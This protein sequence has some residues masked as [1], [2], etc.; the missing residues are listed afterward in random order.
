MKTI[1]L[2]KIIYKDNQ[3]IALKFDYDEDLIEIVKSIKGKKSDKTNN[4]WY[5]PDTKENLSK[6][7]ELFKNKALLDLSWN[8]KRQKAITSKESQVNNNNE[9]KSNIKEKD[10]KKID[11]NI[12][13]T[14]YSEFKVTKRK[15]PKEYLK[16]LETKRCTKN[17]IK[18]YKSMFLSFIN[19]FHY[20][21]IDKITEE[22]IKDFQEYL[23]RDKKVSN[24]YQN[25]SINAIKFYYEH[26]SKKSK[27]TLNFERPK[28]EITLPTI[29]TKKEIMEIFKKVSNI[30]H[31][32]ILNLIYSAGLRISEVANLKIEDID[33]KKMRINVKSDTDKKD[34]ITLLSEKMLIILKEYYAQYKPKDYIFEGP[35]GGS[36]STRSID[37]IFK[38]ALSQT[39][40]KKDATVQTLRHSFA[41]H[42]LESGV[43][44]KYIKEILGH[45]SLKTTE[46]YKHVTKKSLINIRSPFDNM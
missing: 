26:V 44:I 37:K 33:F 4:F 35:T 17:T 39:K 38:K 8:K 15:I 14:K 27:K 45:N 19:Y 34:R 6:I 9:V 29:L 32:C 5:L 43:D 30:K 18:S 10:I 36:Y 2:E 41:T 7:R 25:Q 24:S 22:D 21:T 1:T 13:D 3:I 16:A 42:L 28:R 11:S 40:I 20:K 31:Q 46:I 12:S 23:V